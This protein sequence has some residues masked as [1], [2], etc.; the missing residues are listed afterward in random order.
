MATRA[1]PLGADKSVADL[2]PGEDVVPLMLLVPKRTWDAIKLVAEQD[3]ID[4]MT[5]ISRAI[6]EYMEDRQ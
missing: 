5:L 3:G 6:A 1:K 4:G 2:I